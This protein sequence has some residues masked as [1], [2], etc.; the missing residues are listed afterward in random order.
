MTRFPHKVRQA[1]S[2]SGGA[3]ARLEA[4]AEPAPEPIAP[5][6]GKESLPLTPPE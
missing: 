3:E 1:P 4:A 6:G 2:L 5:S